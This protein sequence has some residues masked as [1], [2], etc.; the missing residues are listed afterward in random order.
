MKI[1]HLGLKII[2]LLIKLNA[3]LSRNNSLLK[4]Y[5]DKNQNLTA[6]IRMISEYFDENSAVYSERMFKKEANLIFLDEDN[7]SNIS[8]A[9]YEKPYYVN[10]IF[11]YIL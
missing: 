2:F 9:V 8:F 3:Y 5:N 10:I 4:I 7:I 6:H 1:I 11:F